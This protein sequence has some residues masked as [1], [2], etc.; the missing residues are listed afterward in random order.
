MIASLFIPHI[1][2]VSMNL[3]YQ[4]TMESIDFQRDEMLLKELSLHI[5]ALQGTQDTTERL[6]ILKQMNAVAFHHCGAKF[7]F[8]LLAEKAPNAFILVPDANIAAPMR[9]D[10]VKETL[11]KSGGVCSEKE[12]F[13]GTVD[14]KKGRV[15][16]VYSEIPM[17][18]FFSVAFLSLTRKNTMFTPEEVAAVLIHEMGHGVMYLRYLGGTVLSNIVIAEVCKLIQDGAEPLIVRNVLKVAEQKTGYKIKDLGTIDK[19]P[20]PLLVQQVVMAEMI[21]RIRSDLGTQ[22]YDARAFEFVAD[23]FAARHGGAAHIVKALDRMYRDCGYK[24][25]EYNSNMTHFM[26]S[27]VVN[28][29]VIIGVCY[30][31]Y[32]FSAAAAI[33]SGGAAV[34]IG[35][36]MATMVTILGGGDIYDDVPNRFKAMRRE[37]IASSKDQNLSQRQRAKL[38]ADIGEIDQVMANITEVKFGP[39]FFSDFFAGV[40]TGKTAQMKFMRT[41]EE[42]ANNRLFE[43]SNQ[44]QA[45]A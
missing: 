14:L 34:V 10:A 4:A 32:T 28:A 19:N 12:F 13:K 15:S 37:L 23:Q 17:D 9:P 6:D 42:L 16:G 5:A 43:L 39:G 30:M 40:F 22:Y 38:I 44:L 11:R 8:H 26:M 35:I 3:H 20:D 24:P 41:L 1:E 31:G 36:A 7:T 45:K 25:L 21:E 29:K 2:T 33:M 27:L 18:I